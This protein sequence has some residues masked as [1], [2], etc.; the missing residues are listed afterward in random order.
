LFFAAEPQTRFIVTSSVEILLT[1]TQFEE[2]HNQSHVNQNCADNEILPREHRD[3]FNS[4]TGNKMKQKSAR[5]S[6]F[7][8]NSLYQSKNKF[9]QMKKERR[10]NFR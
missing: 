6:K 9:V 8:S 4:K 2:A 10:E 5:L 1:L 3:E 7:N